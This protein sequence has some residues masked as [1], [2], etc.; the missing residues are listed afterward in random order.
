MDK[1]DMNTFRR[2]SQWLESVAIRFLIRHEMPR[3]LASRKSS[4]SW[5]NDMNM[6][7]IVNGQ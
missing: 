7:S 2:A 4:A 6:S 5:D 3:I 1:N